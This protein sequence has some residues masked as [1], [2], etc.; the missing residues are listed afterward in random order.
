MR[1]AERRTRAEAR[2]HLEPDQR[3]FMIEEDI[4]E[5]DRQIEQLK[6][7]FHEEMTGLRNELRNTNKILSGLLVTIASGAVVGALNL[8]FKI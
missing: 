7:E 3:L 1:Y 2:R 6:D 5:K 4:D 8:L